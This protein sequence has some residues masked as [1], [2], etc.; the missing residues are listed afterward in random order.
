MNNEHITH[1]RGLVAMS[2]IMPG[3]RVRDSLHGGSG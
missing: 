1:N 2:L 3:D